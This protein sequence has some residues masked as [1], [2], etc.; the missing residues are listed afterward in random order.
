M[1]LL[2]DL[3]PG[4][5]PCG[6]GGMQPGL[7]Y[8][9]MLADPNLDALWI[10]GA[11]PLARATLAAE[12]AFIVVQDLFM[13][14]TAQRAD[15]VLPAA[16]VYEKNGTVTNVCGEVQKL[17]Q[18]PKTMGVKSDL[19]IIT[20]LAK[21]MRADL[22]LT[23]RESIFAEIRRSV[24][25]YDLPVEVLETGGAAH[26]APVNGR[27]TFDSRPELIR[28]AGNTLYTSGTLGRYSKMLGALIESP[29][30]LYQD[31]HKAP[32][33][34]TGSVQLETTVNHD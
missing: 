26:T 18:G 21:E 13:T 11:N 33:V 23:T 20:L 29:G 14:E 19:E 34:K 31:P 4:Y 30:A 28:P 8:D 24:R 1:G 3:L 16:S 32:V 9:Q 7:N 5:K 17:T 2:P 25:G 15:V 12:K 6:E 22:G 27:I 10:V